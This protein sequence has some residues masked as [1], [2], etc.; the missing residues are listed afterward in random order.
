MADLCTGCTMKAEDFMDTTMK[1]VHL[2]CDEL[3]NMV[4]DALEWM[5]ADIVDLRNNWVYQK[6]PG[7]W[8]L[9]VT[10]DHPIYKI[11]GFYGKGTKCNSSILRPL[12]E[13]NWCR[14][15]CW[16]Y[17]WLV[18][19]DVGNAPIQD[20]IPGQYHYCRDGASR[21]LSINIPC[22]VD[23][24]YVKYMKG[25][26]RLTNIKD[27]LPIS[28]RLL[29]ALRLVIKAFYSDESWASFAG[30]DSKYLAQYKEYIDK[31]KEHDIP[32][33]RY[34]RFEDWLM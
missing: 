23:D 5:W 15:E 25:F 30:D 28:S 20:L 10:T 9:E 17:Q 26:S 34:V 31:I 13:E 22:C 21:K 7:T 1:W 27:C 12:D 2:A 6:I 11:D 19:F 16:D 29:P 24:V 33:I 8:I 4:N 18:S 3:L 14:C 32:D